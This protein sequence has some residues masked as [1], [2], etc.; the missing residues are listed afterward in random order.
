M[1]YKYRISSKI[2]YNPPFL[3]TDY[4][5]IEILVYYFK[6]CFIQGVISNFK[7]HISYFRNLVYQS[8][9]QFILAF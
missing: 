7:N 2:R 9:I 6:G 3:P 1:G 4:Y 8:K 5:G